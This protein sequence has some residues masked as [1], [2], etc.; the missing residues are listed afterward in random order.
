MTKLFEGV[1][2]NIHLKFVCTL[3]S[4]SIILC[5]GSSIQINI[6]CGLIT[7]LTKTNNLYVCSHAHCGDRTIIFL[8]YYF[9][10]QRV[11]YPKCLCAVNT[12]IR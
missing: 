3:V 6:Y 5:E 9:G 11:E 7:L 8:I 2:S 1:I 4:L 12:E 10:R